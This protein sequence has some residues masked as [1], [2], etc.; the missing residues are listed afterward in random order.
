VRDAREHL[1]TTGDVAGKHQRE[2]DAPSNGRSSTVSS[3]VMQER[4]NRGPAPK[5]ALA[6]DYWTSHNPLPC[7]KAYSPALSATHLSVPHSFA[8]ISRGT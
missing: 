6:L 1:A 7:D 8:L 4:Y 2:E 3:C 5:N